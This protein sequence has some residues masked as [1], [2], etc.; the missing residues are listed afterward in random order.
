MGRVIGSAVAGYAAMFVCIF[1]LMTVAWLVM[2][3]DGA[4][5]PGVWDVT[6]TWLVLM[7]LAAGVAAIAGGYVTATISPDARAIKILIGIVIVLGIVSA[8]PVIMQSAPPPE[9]PRPDE[10]P[11]FEAMSKG[12]QPLWLALL[13]PLIGV[14]GV[15]AGGKL[16]T[17]N[18]KVARG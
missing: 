13:N 11:M 6:S 17:R 10:L 7:I 9:L 16:K 5:R 8:L 4:F 12:Q 1:V 14:V 3:V 2:G 18:T 15:I